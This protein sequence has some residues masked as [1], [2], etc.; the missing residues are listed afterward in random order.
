MSSLEHLELLDHLLDGV[1]GYD[2]LIQRAVEVRCVREPRDGGCVL[3]SQTSAYGDVDPAIG[4]FYESF[5]CVGTGEDVW[6]STGGEDAVAAEGDEGFEG[7][8]QGGRL[9]EGSVEGDGH[10][11]G[12]CDELLC[13]A[14]V[15]LV[16]GGEGAEDDTG[17]S[18]L[19]GVL[20]VFDHHGDLVI[21]VAEAA[22]SRADHDV[23][24][25]RGEADGCG[26]EAVA[27]GEATFR[28]GGAELDASGT[29]C[30]GGEA[31]VKGLGA[32]F[33]DDGTHSWIILRCSYNGIP[34]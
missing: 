28:E 24:R 34:L 11:S 17:G 16:A 27:G 1:G 25:Q 7:V 31:G 8:G 19:P 5:Q 10:R 15:Y 3:D 9:V 29:A 30:A 12:R 23:D 6:M 4:L 13:E 18:E 32:E 14:V 26:Y 20:Y 21:G 2:G 33:E 22:S